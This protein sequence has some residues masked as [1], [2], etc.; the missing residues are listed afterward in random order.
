MI[1]ETANQILNRV[2]P[3]CT[4]QVPGS[5]N[6]TGPA[7]PRFPGVVREWRDFGLDVIL[8]RHFPG[9]Q[10]P[11][12]PTNT[13]D[14]HVEED[15]KFRFY[16]NVISP[17]V[18]LLGGALFKHRCIGMLGVSDFKTFH[19]LR[20]GNYNLW[21]IYRYA[22]RAQ[23][24]DQNFRFIKRILSQVFGEMACNGLHYGILTSYSDTYFLRRSENEPNNLYVS[25]VF[26]PDSINPTL[27]ECVFHISHLAIN[28]TYL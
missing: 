26:H 15:A 5:T 19:N 14:L 8:N 2:V 17:V 25:H 18:P 13:E 7:Y 20:L 9:G 21:E 24:T 22:D 27:R 3:V 28:D 6:S 16:S 11:A 10:F 4:W 1:T 12:F 23:I